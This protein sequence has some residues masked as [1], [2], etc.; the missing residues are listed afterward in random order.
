MCFVCELLWLE[1]KLLEPR[2]LARVEGVIVVVKAWRAWSRVIFV[3]V[4]SKF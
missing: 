3:M 1:A 2:G 4:L